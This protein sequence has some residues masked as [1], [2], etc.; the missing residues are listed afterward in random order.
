MTYFL[1]ST[2]FIFDDKFIQGQT[3]SNSIDASIINMFQKNDNI[4]IGYSNPQYPL[5]V[6]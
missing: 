4:G 1:G 2:G 5:H 3:A 6:T